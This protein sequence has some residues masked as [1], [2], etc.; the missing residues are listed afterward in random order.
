MTVTS[1]LAGHDT[2]EVAGALDEVELVGASEGDTD[3]ILDERGAVG[4]LE[5]TETTDA[6]ED[7]AAEGTLDGTEADG[8]TDKVELVELDE[9][10]ETG[11]KVPPQTLP[12]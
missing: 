10:G 6:L 1:L 9:D 3:A 8:T 2:E 12:L 7:T 5:E 4:A 11:L